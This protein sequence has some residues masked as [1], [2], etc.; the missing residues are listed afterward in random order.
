MRPIVARDL[1][2]PDILAVGEEM[3]VVQTAAFLLEHEITGAPVRAADGSFV[4]FVSTS[5]LLRAV[6]VGGD[7]AGTLDA[8]VSEVMTPEIYTIDADAPVP[9]VARTLLDGGIHRVFVEE[10]GELVG[11]VSSSDL[12]GLLI[13]AD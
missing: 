11:A 5:D 10:D 12:V 4:G 3:T 13:D 2:A 1:M 7:E 6:A 9:E 8:P